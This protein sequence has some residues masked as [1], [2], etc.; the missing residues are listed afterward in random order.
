MTMNKRYE[1]GYR[2]CYLHYISTSSCIQTSCHFSRNKSW[3]VLQGWT[4]VHAGATCHC[5]CS[6]SSLSR[7]KRRGGFVKDKAGWWSQWQCCRVEGYAYMDTQQVKTSN[8][9]R[10]QRGVQL[11]DEVTNIVGCVWLKLDYIRA[12]Q[13]R[14]TCDL[15][16]CTKPSNALNIFN[17]WSCLCRGDP[18]LDPDLRWL[19]WLAG[20]QHVRLRLLLIHSGSCVVQVVAIYVSCIMV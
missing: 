7:F 5:R 12:T 16:A 11:E 8:M 18:V 2:M 15:F 1:G 17:L 14:K 6:G 3:A 13:H 9:K 4:Y 20:F 10:H 19:T